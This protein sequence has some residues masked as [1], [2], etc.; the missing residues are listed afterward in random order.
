MGGYAIAGAG[1]AVEVAAPQPGQVS[2]SPGEGDR[3]AE[4]ASEAA[5]AEGVSPPRHRPW[6]RL[7]VVPIK[8]QPGLRVRAPLVCVRTRPADWAG[9]IV[10][11]ATMRRSSALRS[12]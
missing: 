5:R 7:T 2:P 1:N 6:P 3:A 12:G 8:R 4:L 10:M 9:Q 11:E